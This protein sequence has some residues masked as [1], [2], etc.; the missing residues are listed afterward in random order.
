[1]DLSSFP[2]RPSLLSSS[3]GWRDRL[4]DASFRGVPF[5]VEEESAG[6]GR[7]VETHEYPNR[8]KPYTEDLGKVTFRPS[9]TAYVVGDDCFDQRD[10]LIEALNKPG[11]GTLV[12]PTYGEL[13]VCVDGEVRVSTSKSEGRI[14]R[15]ER[16]SVY[17]V[18]G[19]RAGNDDDFGEATTTALRA[20]TEDA[21]IARYRP[22]Y[23]RQTGQATGAGCIARA[24]FEARQRA[25][26]TDETTYVVQ[27][28]RQGNGTLW[29]PNQRVIV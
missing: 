17:Q 3:S 12:H 22:M 29:Q 2:T 9:I 11:P 26:R 28:W 5:K 14:V 20:R 1:M 15:F 10:R 7:R 21:F 24:D 19:Q 8:D 6:T 18:A 13:K 4:Q 23:I 16:F 27:G 25:A